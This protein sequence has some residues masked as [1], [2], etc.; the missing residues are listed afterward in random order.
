M[1]Y[2][3]LFRLSY[4]SCFL[5]SRCFFLSCR[6]ISRDTLENTF[7]FEIVTYFL[8][9]VNSWP[10]SRWILTTCSYI[11]FDRTYFVFHIPSRVLS[12]YIYIYS[13]R[14]LLPILYTCWTVKHMLKDIII[15]SSISFVFK[16]NHYKYHF[17]APYM[18]LPHN[19]WQAIC[20][21]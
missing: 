1:R 21:V 4:T 14:Y 10:K 3:I 18:Y 5:V 13:W 6:G 2:H 7:L 8:F 17:A 16:Y 20:W 11:I 15:E 9:P 19:S 12:K